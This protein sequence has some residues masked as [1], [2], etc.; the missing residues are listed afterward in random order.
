MISRLRGLLI[1]KQPPRLV[2]DVHGVG[3]EVL[4]PISTFYELP[5]LNQ[6][7]SL[8][9]YL[10]VREDAQI[11]YGF[12]REAEREWFRSLIRVNGV[13]PKLALSILSTMEL[14]T[15][16][17]CV[18]QNDTARLIRIP[19]VGKKTAERLVVEMRDRLENWRT[20]TSSSS[21]A[22]SASFTQDLI[23]PVDDAISALIAL[24][25]KPQEASRWV[26]A[27]AEEGLTSE[28]LIRRALQSA[29]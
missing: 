16:V 6:E 22:S 24:G 3:Y 15:F 25:Y 1:E 11:L 21:P 18:H 7:V 29:S 10:S 12:I 5:E 2:I 28:V 17:Q 19:G 14:T 4:A 26:H 9:T 13:G 27:V 8:L 20:S 23:S